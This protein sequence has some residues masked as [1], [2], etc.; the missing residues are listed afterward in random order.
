VIKLSDERH[1]LILLQNWIVSM[2]VVMY[3]LSRAQHCYG[4]DGHVSLS[5]CQIYAVDVLKI[6]VFY[7]CCYRLK[8]VDR[9]PAAEKAGKSLKPVL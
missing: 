7:G 2:A 3:G 9:K 1:A 6:A 5:R 8:Y 4:S